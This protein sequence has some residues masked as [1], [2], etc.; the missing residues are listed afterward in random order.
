MNYICRSHRPMPRHRLH[1]ALFLTALVTNVPAFAETIH[2][3]P[4]TAPTSLRDF[5]VKTGGRQAYGLYLNNKKIGWMVAEV[6]LTQHDGHEVA[7]YHTEGYFTLR[8]LTDQTKVTKTTDTFFSL[9]GDG[10][11]VAMDSLDREN[12]TERHRT[13]TRDG[14][15]LL[16]TTDI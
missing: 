1:I 13:A 6:K 16:I 9:Q 14:A 7:D 12:N 11:I 10:P 3:P 15:N 4:A 8:F 2:T 5:V